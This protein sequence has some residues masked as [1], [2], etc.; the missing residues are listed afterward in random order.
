MSAS[1][2]QSTTADRSASTTPYS[3]TSEIQNRLGAL[4]PSTWRLLWVLWLGVIVCATTIYSNIFVGHSHWNL[5]QWIPS[6]GVGTWWEYAS[7]VVTNM[8]LFA[9]LGFIQRPAGFV[10]ASRTLL[11][12]A[13]TG[14]LVSMSVELVQVYSHNR[15][16][17]T[18]DLASNTLGALCGGLTWI[19]A[20]VRYSTNS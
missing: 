8:A 19:R 4:S 3:Q 6:P 14:L 5:V 1:P 9:P 2:S 17:S 13:V 18:S 12:I 7:D 11:W 10:G 15:L 20:G 16:G